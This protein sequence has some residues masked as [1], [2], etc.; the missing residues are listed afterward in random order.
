VRPY[1]WIKEMERLKWERRS[2]MFEPRAM[3]TRREVGLEDDEG[4]EGILVGT[5]RVMPLEWSG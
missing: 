3:N 2:P 4:V 5:I 1:D